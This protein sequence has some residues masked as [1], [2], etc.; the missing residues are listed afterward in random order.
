MPELHVPDRSN[1]RHAP[2]FQEQWRQYR[3]FIEFAVSYPKI[4]LLRGS[5]RVNRN[6][7]F[8][9]LLPSALYTTMLSLLDDALE[10]V[11]FERPEF[12]GVRPRLSDRIDALA[13][14]GLVRNPGALHAVRRRRDAVS[15]ELD[16]SIGWDGLQQDGTVIEAELVSLG[17]VEPVPQM[18]FFH[19]KSALQPSADSNAVG[20][21]HFK[22]GVRSGD[23]E[24]LVWQFTNTLMKSSIS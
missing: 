15:Q 19:E 7:I 2:R 18:Q 3:A 23:Q 16:S 17:L 12:A 6:P 10:S 24:V 9:M 14:A 21:I 1:G 13:A 20:D 22:F 8:D 4:E 5:R 11:I